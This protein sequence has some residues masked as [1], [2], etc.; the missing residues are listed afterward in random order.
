MGKTELQ[1]AAV[2]GFSDE[3][4]GRTKV[5]T[6]LNF[7]KEKRKTLAK[8]DME[9]R[10]PVTKRDAYAQMLKDPETGEWVLR[11]NFHT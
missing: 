10:W 9:C 3:V 4:R 1:F 7:Q 8:Y 2:G 6:W 11:Y 5:E